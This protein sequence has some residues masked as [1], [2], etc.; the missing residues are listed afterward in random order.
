MKPWG[1]GPLV[2]SHGERVH[3]H[4]Y[5]YYLLVINSAR[6]SSRSVPRAVRTIPIV[7]PMARLDWVLSQGLSIK[8]AVAK[9][10]IR[11]HKHVSSRR[12]SNLPPVCLFVEMGGCFAKANWSRN[13]DIRFTK[14]NVISVQ[15]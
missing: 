4:E 12:C 3:D 7:T 14:T 8:K 5:I 2:P 9:G 1:N 10:M 13:Q 11:F 15:Y 6:M